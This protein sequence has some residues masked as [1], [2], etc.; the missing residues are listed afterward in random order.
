MNIYISKVLAIDKVPRKIPIQYVASIED[1][2]HIVSKIQ[3]LFRDQKLLVLESILRT[4]EEENLAVADIL[5]EEMCCCLSN[6]TKI[7]WGE[8]N[9]GETVRAK[10]H[11]AENPNS[12]VQQ[13]STGFVTWEAAKCLAWYLSTTSGY[14]RVIELG[15]GTGVTGII[16][17][18]FHSDL[19]YVFT[20]YHEDTLAQAKGNW[21]LNEKDDQRV[22]FQILDFCKDIITSPEATIV[23]ADILYDEQL[24][25][26]LIQILQ[27]S[28]FKE[29]L[30]MS[31][32]R[33][34]S[35]YMYFLKTL[36]KTNLQFSIIKTQKFM[37]WVQESD[38]EWKGFFNSSTLLFD[39]IIELVSIKM[40]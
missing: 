10:F 12:F 24:C 6:R 11:V 40:A 4:C 21:L 36:E 38:I 35:T 14:E 26:G 3:N 18:Q 28:V 20:D 13:G 25:D 8:Y 32:I 5:Y 29:A 16:V 2:I 15:C 34:E 23:G 31:T 7:G 19:E 37:Q 17:S 39:P 1:Q 33:T 9:V 27:N 30:I 22:E